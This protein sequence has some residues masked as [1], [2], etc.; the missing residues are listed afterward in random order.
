M[1]GLEEALLAGVTEAFKA[2]SAG[3]ARGRKHEE[4]LERPLQRRWC[5]GGPARLD[6]SHL[7]PEAGIVEGGKG[8]LS[9]F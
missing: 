9:Q 4:T 5:F 8:R 3:T 1:T 6:H 7:P 2:G